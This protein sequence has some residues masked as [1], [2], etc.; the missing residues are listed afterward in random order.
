MN[1][2][3]GPI[4]IFLWVIALYHIL[5]GA[6]LIFSGEMSISAADALYGWQ[7]TGSPELGILGEILGCY[8][9]AFGLMMAVAA[10]DPARFRSLLTVGIVLIALRLVQRLFFAG[11]VM[12]VFQVSSGRYWG[13]FVFVLLLGAILTWVRLQVRGESAG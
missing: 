7:I 13:A 1:K 4:R 12:E 6:L 9:I 11:K 5:L 10:G 2:F 8:A 3:Q